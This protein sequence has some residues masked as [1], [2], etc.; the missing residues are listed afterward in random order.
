MKKPAE[1]LIINI[2]I[3]AFIIRLIPSFLGMLALLYALSPYYGACFVPLYRF[4]IQWLKSSYETV[5]LNFASSTEGRQFQ[6]VI[7]V[8]EPF[9]DK[10]GRAWDGVTTKGALLAS[11][12]YI[13]PLIVFPLLIAWP[14]LL[15]TDRIKAVIIAV[16]LVIVITSVDITI[17]IINGV[18]MY[19]AGT[20]ASAGGHEFFYYF[21]NNGG[22]QFLSLI[23]FLIALA[24][25]Y[26][27]KVL[28]APRPVSLKTPC[29]C[30]S[31]LKYKHCCYKNRS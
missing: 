31:G 4:Q 7:R 6:Y 15:I 25:C 10:Q 12:I 5:S 16:L 18:K 11:S 3:R 13:Y 24:P 21:L 23:I 1:L 30:G 17:K 29:P 27:R 9:V 22:S 8:N 28:S 14:G 26:L 2:H 20:V 19:Y